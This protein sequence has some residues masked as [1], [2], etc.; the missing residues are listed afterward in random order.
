MCF[1]FFTSIPVFRALRSSLIVSSSSLSS[2]WLRVRPRPRRAPSRRARPSIELPEL[3]LAL[4]SAGAS[5]SDSVPDLSCWLGQV[6]EVSLFVASLSRPTG[7]TWRAS[8]RGPRAARS[9]GGP[10]APEPLPL[11]VAV[12]DLLPVLDG[13][14][15]VVEE[16]DE[17]ALFAD[18]ALEVALGLEDPVPVL[19]EPDGLLD[20]REP[21]LRRDRP[22]LLDHALVHYDQEVV[23]VD[24]ELP[25]EPHDLAL[26]Y[27]LVVGLVPVG[28]VLPKIPG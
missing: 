18:H 23:R 15:G 22:Q 7:A 1:I 20:H 27:L 11:E 25:E 17:R 24:P 21:L 26:V 19:P 12:V 10:G 5:A 8:L 9:P 3:H 16:L 2:P 13:L 28:A 6:L 4:R 14:V